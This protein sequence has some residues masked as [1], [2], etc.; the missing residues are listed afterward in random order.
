MF[1]SASTPYAATYRDRYLARTTA[2]LL[3]LPCRGS[4]NTWPP[5]PNYTVQPI[6]DGRMRM[7]WNARM[8]PGSLCQARLLRLR[9]D[10]KLWDQE[11]LL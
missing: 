1:G 10:M 8:A 6:K 9:L 7:P 5:S 11:S 4:T 3:R 2:L